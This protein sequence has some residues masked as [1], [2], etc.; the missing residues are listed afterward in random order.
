MMMMMDIDDDLLV[1][2]SP[3]LEQRTIVSPRFQPDGLVLLLHFR[4]ERSST[5]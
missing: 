2:F 5:R 1:K 3:G 4:E